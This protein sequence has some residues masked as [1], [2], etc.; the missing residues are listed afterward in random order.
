[1]AMRKRRLPCAVRTGLV[2]QVAVVSCERNDRVDTR[3]N[4]GRRRGPEALERGAADGFCGGC[5]CP[6]VGRIV[7]L[8]VIALKRDFDG[9]RCNDGRAIAGRHEL[10]NGAERRPCPARPRRDAKLTSVRCGT[11]ERET[12][13]G[14]RNSNTRS[15]HTRVAEGRRLPRIG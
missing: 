14:G 9:A 1:Q 12:E 13:M 7:V 2:V 5:P 6:L 10:R 4:D 15:T 8:V 3:S 11:N